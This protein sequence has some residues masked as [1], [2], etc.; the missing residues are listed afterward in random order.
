M[1]TANRPLSPHL[2]V[3]RWKLTMVMSILH[4]ASGILLAAAA[5]FIVYWLAAAAGGPGSYARAHALFDFWLVELIMFA[6]TFALFYHL[7][8]GIR[9]LLW[10]AGRGFEMEEVY[11]SGYAVAGATVVLTLLAWLLALL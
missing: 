3:Y 7:C 6:W 8:N 4:R 10:D 11:R 1:S 5:P 2:Q 9:H